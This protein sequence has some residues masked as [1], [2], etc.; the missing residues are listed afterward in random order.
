MGAVE[1][2]FLLLAPATYFG[3][4]AVERVLPARKFPHRPGWQWI[5]IAFLLLSMAIGNVLPLYLPLD[6]LAEHRWLDGTG[7]G[8]VGGAIVGFI[9]LELAVYAW[10]RSVHTFSPMW[11]V[12]HQ[13]HH[14][15]RASTLRGRSCS[16]RSKRW[17][18]R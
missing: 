10:H 4:L 9:V 13:I 6:W 3:M 16:T 15:P 7:L 11:R 17:P 8:V 5:G 2:T 12:F 1:L 18:I 14:S